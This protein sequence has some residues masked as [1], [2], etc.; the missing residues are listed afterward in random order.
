LK[1][2]RIASGLVR[3]WGCRLASAS[4]GLFSDLGV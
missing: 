1:M 2:V 3:N 4:L